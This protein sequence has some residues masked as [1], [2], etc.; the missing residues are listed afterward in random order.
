MRLSILGSFSAA[1]VSTV[2]LA[3]LVFSQPAWAAEQSFDV[4]AFTKIRSAGSA[5]VRVTTGARTAVVASGDAADLERLLIEVRDGVLVIGQKP[6]RWDWRGSGVTVNVSTPRLAEAS[7]TGTGDIEIDRMAEPAVAVAV[8]G[9]GDMRV[10]RIDATTVAARLAGSGNILLAG[11]CG[12]GRFDLAGSGDIMAS[13]LACETL[14]AAIKGSG[15]IIAS[16]SRT[17][18]LTVLGSGDIMVEGGAQCT[19]TTRG[20]GTITCR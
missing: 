6:G 11:R 2:A 1:L 20:S 7:L 9:A 8:S 13:A 5:D 15:D 3:A 14:S 16:A 18:D 4:S 12:T 17:A 10:G 19:R